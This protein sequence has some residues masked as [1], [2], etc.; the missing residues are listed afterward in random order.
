[1]RLNSAREFFQKRVVKK[2]AWRLGAALLLFL[3]LIP[4][5]QG[6]K[7]F[8]AES[9]EMPELVEGMYVKGLRFL[10][11][12][13][14]PEGT[15][16]ENRYGSEPGVVGLAVVSMLAHGDNPNWGPYSEAIRRGLNYILSEFNEQTG[17]IGSTMYNHGF[18]TLALAESYGEVDD[19]RIG[20]ALFKAV[21]LILNAQKDNPLGAWRYSPTS[22][23]A[24]TT[25]TGCEMVALFAA[26]NA[27]VPVPEAAIQK[28]LKFMLDCQHSSG[29]FGYTSNSAP[30]GPR[31]AIGCLILTLAK[32]KQ[33]QPW[34]SAFK[35]L[36]NAPPQGTYYYY[37]LYYASQAY[38]HASPEDWQTWNLKNIRE[39]Q[40]AQ[41]ENGSW[42]GQFGTTFSTAASL[43]SLALNY[44][45]LPI[46]ER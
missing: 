18:A 44:R 31:T 25:V 14:S 35:F 32:E 27:G 42:D 2:D 1:M 11:E 39:L 30:N 3:F 19:P 7:L 16:A 6:Q 38:F 23:D 34:K 40:G 46:Y 33:N 28:G 15:W 21:N 36:K 24:D 8:E 13:Q 26:R 20:P 37:Y 22:Q 17:F 4:P 12:T 29:G 5:I 45:Y 10:A 41:N 9:D 43:L